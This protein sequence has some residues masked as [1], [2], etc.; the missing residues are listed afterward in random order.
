MTDCKQPVSV[1]FVCTGNICRSPMAEAVFQNLVNNAGLAHCFHIASAATSTWEIGKPPHPGTQE[2][3]RINQIPLISG[4]RARQIT[5]DDTR[6]Y[7]YV[8]VMDEENVRDM[9]SVGP[10]QRLMEYAPHMAVRDVPDPY[11]THDFGFTYQL[12]NAACKGLLEHIRAE[13][14]F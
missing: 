9:R 11:Y 3:L 1:L 6:K 14:G 13:H 7:D 10:S 12:V 5:S 8:L 2:I 4:K